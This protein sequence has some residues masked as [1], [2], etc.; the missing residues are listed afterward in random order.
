VA[1]G[2]ESKSVEEQQ[3]QAVS[4][5]SPAGPPLTPAQIAVARR[6]QGLVLS[7]QHVMQQ[8]EAAKN[9]RHREI[10]QNAL[11]DLD[12]QLAQLV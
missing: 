2:W 4:K 11:A 1:R 10:L 6:K 9:S 8:L 5:V 3:A 12:R 7:R